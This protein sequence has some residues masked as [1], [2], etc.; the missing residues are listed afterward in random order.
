MI[1]EEDKNR[2]IEASK[3]KDCLDWHHHCHAECCKIIF[4]NIDPK[5]LKN[6]RKYIIIKLK[7]IFS[8]WRYY[9]LRDV[10][11]LRGMLRFRKDRIV[12]VGR[13]V[14]Y[15]YPCKLLNGNLCMGHPDKKPEIC[16]MLTLE[17]AKIPGQPFEL[18]DNCLFKY[19]C[20]EV[21]KDDQKGKN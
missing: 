15:I 17:T 21:K 1:S 2:Y 18:T 8:D 11:Y 3:C 6:H 13:K 9:N 10:E 16:K 4:I 7:P 14:M 19:K 20:K 12:V 5:E